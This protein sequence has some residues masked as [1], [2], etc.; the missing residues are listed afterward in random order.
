MADNEKNTVNRENGS[1]AMDINTDESISGTSHLNEPVT[2]EDEVEKLKA[3]IA[4]LKDKYLRQ[5]AEF[6]NFRRR[7]AKERIEMIQTAGKEVVTS[8][9]DVL[10]DCDRAEKQLQAS[11]DTLLKEGIQLVFADGTVAV[12]DDAAAQD[13]GLGAPDRVIDPYDEVDAG[14]TSEFSGIAYDPQQDRL[15]V[16]DVGDTADTTDGRIFVIEGASTADGDTTPSV[17]IEGAS[18][19]LGNPVALSLKGVALRVA[20]TGTDQVLFYTNVFVAGTGDIA[21]AEAYAST[22][23]V[24]LVVDPL[25]IFPP[26]NHTNGTVSNIAYVSN[27]PSAATQVQ[28]YDAGLTTAGNTFDAGQVSVENLTFDVNGDGYAT[29]DDN[30]DALGTGGIM[31]VHRLAKGRDGDTGLDADRDRTITGA[32]T[33]LAAPKGIIMLGATGLVAVAESSANGVDGAGIYVYNA[34]QGDNTAP[35]FT[36]ATSGTPWDVDYVAALDT[37]FVAQTNGTVDIYGDFVSRLQAADPMDPVALTLTVDLTGATNLHGIHYDLATD[38][39]ILSDVGDPASATDGLLWVVTDVSGLIA[40]AADPNADDDDA[41]ALTAVTLPLDDTT[42]EYANTAF[43]VNSDGATVFGNPVDIAYDGANLYVA[44]KTGTTAGILLFEDFLDVLGEDEFSLFP[45][46]TNL[47][48]DADTD[49]DEVCEED[50]GGTCEDFIVDAEADAE[51]AATAAESISLVP[52][53]LSTAP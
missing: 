28:H 53:F 1:N 10:D 31:I 4:E 25:K 30:T 37:L 29:F 7:T 17:Q 46:D 50:G 45:D 38:N 22:D 13:F 18:T 47:P 20:D 48:A 35:V 15:V 12:F 41:D 27:Q 9:L 23:P 16:S 34:C 39:L 42:N 6:E 19:E 5:V 26:V 11:D 49:P 3:E 36:I 8:L 32:T 43:Q 14:T 40:Y 2:N 21:P 33:G 44:N 51:L 24:G 52:D